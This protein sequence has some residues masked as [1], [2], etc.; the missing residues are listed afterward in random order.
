MTLTEQA[1]AIALRAHGGQVRKT[2]DSPYI[3]HPIMVSQL[4]AR[5]GFSDVVCAAALV[6]DVLEDTN[7]AEEALRAALG[8]EVVQIVLK[9]T[10]DKSLRWEERKQQYCDV[11]RAGSEAVKAVSIADKIHN[12]E[13]LLDAYD[14]HGQA[15]WQAFNRGKTEK[16]WF[17]ENMLGMLKES[18]EHPLVL[19]YEA[20]VLKMRELG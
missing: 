10:E 16:L 2:D 1:L 20:L 15:L 8:E 12:L 6:H 3:I 9:V 19:R 13:S 5:H 7:V 14:R 17:E 18:W 4:L 11:V